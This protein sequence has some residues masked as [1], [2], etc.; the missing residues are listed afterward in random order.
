MEV[1]STLF[2]FTFLL[3]S[4]FGVNAQQTHRCQH[5]DPSTE[6]LKQIKSLLN[7]SQKSTDL[8]IIPV[9]FHVLHQNGYENIAD[10]Q[11]WDAM[12]YLNRDFQRLNPDTSNVG[13]PFD[14]IIGKVDFEFR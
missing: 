2:L 1:K 12:E 3:A 14:T 5:P 13:A 7:Q 9:V 4:S 8:K 6:S 10:A 11:I